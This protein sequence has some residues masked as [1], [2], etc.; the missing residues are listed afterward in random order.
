MRLGSVKLLAP[1]EHT[2]QMSGGTDPREDDSEIGTL[3]RVRCVRLSTCSK[4]LT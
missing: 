2:T 3:N 4:T 1:D